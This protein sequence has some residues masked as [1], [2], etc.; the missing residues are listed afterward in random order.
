[1]RMALILALLSLLIPGFH[2]TSVSRSVFVATTTS[3]RDTG[4]LNDLLPNVPAIAVG[5][6]KALQMGMRKEAH[7]VIS[8]HPK[9]EHQFMVDG[10]GIQRRPFMYNRF[11]I[12]GP[13][14]DPAGVS[15]T[16]TLP[17]AFKALA[18]NHARFISRGDGS[19]TNARE[20][21]IWAKTRGSR[22]S[23]RYISTGSGMGATLATTESLGGYTLTDEAT[24]K[25]LNPKLRLFRFDNEM[26][27]NIYSALLVSELARDAFNHVTSVAVAKIIQRR[28]FVP[29]RYN[30]AIVSRSEKLPDTRTLCPDTPVRE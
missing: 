1:M 15:K 29:C 13:F 9:L 7:L 5:S 25:V 4:L 26:S 14:D 6:G 2:A 24:F 19:G 8:H 11:V 3:V 21:A 12:V 22:F 16:H 10:F 20:I 17:E 23:S 18:D 30:S 27:L 28:G